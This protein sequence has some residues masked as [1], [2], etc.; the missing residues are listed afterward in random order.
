MQANDQLYSRPASPDTAGE[1]DSS[2]PVSSKWTWLSQKV[3]F[4][5]KLGI[6][7]PRRNEDTG[8]KDYRLFFL[9][10]AFTIYRIGSM[11]MNDVSIRAVY[12]I[13][14]FVLILHYSGPD[15]TPTATPTHNHWH[16][17]L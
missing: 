15:L 13:V 12:N 17:W 8:R 10:I 3:N 14:C 1:N 9:A 16:I 4:V 2:K 5:K 6:F 7:L 11:Y